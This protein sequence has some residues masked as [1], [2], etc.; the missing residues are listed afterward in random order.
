MTELKERSL[1]WVRN[2]GEDVRIDG[3]DGGYLELSIHSSYE[4]HLSVSVSPHDFCTVVRVEAL[5]AA[6]EELGHLEKTNSRCKKLKKKG[7]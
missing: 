7:K 2:G 4:D 5:M 3:D 6:L 1:V